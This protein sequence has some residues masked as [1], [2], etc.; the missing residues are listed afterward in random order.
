[1]KRLVLFAFAAMLL[2]GC[3]K[4]SLRP[5]LDFT[6]SGCASGVPETKGIF[7]E[8]SKLYLKYTDKGLAVIHTNAEVNCIIKENGYVCEVSVEGNTIHYSVH[9]DWNG[10][11]ANC[12]CLVK[13]MS[14][15]VTGLKEG[16]KYVL[17][18]FCDRN[19]EPIE[20]VY[21]KGLDMHVNLY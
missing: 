8:D 21:K 2:C 19:Y 15:T 13:E 4:E 16:T 12:N 18:Y 20:F 1:M 5:S 11:V 10:P 17:D 14:S 6:H 3:A 7:H 9:P